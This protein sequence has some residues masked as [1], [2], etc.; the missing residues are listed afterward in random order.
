MAANMQSTLAHPNLYHGWKVLGAISL[1]GFLVY[2]GGLY[3]FVLFVT[4]LTREFGWT[5]AETSG[6]VSAFWLSAPLLIFGGMAMRR[7]GVT[8]LL[9][10]G[11]ILE[12]LC[13]LMLANVSTLWQMYL[14]R[15]AM[16]FGKV[17]FG[18]TVPVTIA[19][20]FSRRFGLALGIAWA[21]WHI[22]GMVLAP[23]TQRIID[24][25]GWR[26]ACVALG[27]ALVTL[28]L[29]P[30]LWV[31]RIRS[32]AQLGLG[33][34]GDELEP[35]PIGTQSHDQIGP[36]TSVALQVDG[37]GSLLRSTRFWLIVVATLFFYIVYGGLLTQQ[38]AVVEN[39]GYSARLASIV[40]GSTAGFAALG[41]VGTGWLMDRASLLVSATLINGLLL[42][43]AGALVTAT[44]CKSVLALVA[45]AA[46]FGLAIGGSDVCFVKLMRD[47]F[48][49]VKLEYTYSIWY[50]VELLTLWL[51]P[52][53]AGRIFDLSR[54]YTRTLELMVVC[55][56]MA[57]V[58]SIIA[59]RART[60]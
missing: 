40:L 38:A 31:Q 17:M 49:H 24:A 27:I 59:A 45:Y 47:S 11:I 15:A 23:L 29:G 48:P 58:L 28:A 37:I 46:C 41:C 25:F 14:L 34:D 7:F 36:R 60:A 21:G 12:A 51:A 42:F 55:A 2:G 54:S 13:V 53:A 9:A 50:C 16:G 18:V 39:S 3:S 57:G 52:I 32:P 26:T 6:I 22:G 43:G 44:S 8:R 35:G 10:A 20:W 4:P 33:L 30:V 56:A 19:R 5:R 1:A